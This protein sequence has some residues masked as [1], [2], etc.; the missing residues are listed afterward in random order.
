[1]IVPFSVYDVVDATK[2]VVIHSYSH[3]TAACEWLNR[4]IFGDPAHRWSL[5]SN[6]M[7]ARN[8]AAFKHAYIE[9]A[10]LRHRL[11]VTLCI[12]GPDNVPTYVEVSGYPTLSCYTMDAEKP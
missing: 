3:N 4:A 6:P 12:T 7:A 1:M 11:P 8:D 10:E 2:V 5:N 9:A